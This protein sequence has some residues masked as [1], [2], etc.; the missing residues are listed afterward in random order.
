MYALI[1]YP[2]G[3]IIEAAILSAT[4]DRLRVISSGLPDALD[5][6]RSGENWLTDTGE[7][8]QLEFLVISDSA[9]RTDG[10]GTTVARAAGA[11]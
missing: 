7:Q 9:V 5:L 4:H 1:S 10:A 8:V 2:V 11:A 6:R 3:V